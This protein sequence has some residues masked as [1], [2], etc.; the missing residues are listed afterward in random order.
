VTVPE[1]R[2]ATIDVDLNLMMQDESQI[3]RG[4][5]AR[6]LDLGSIK[7]LELTRVSVVRTVEAGFLDVGCRHDRTLA[8]AGRYVRRRAGP[9][10]IQNPTYG[11]WI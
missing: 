10:T 2:G 6:M 11:D 3:Q 8:K 5:P 7:L 4:E 9:T 1:S